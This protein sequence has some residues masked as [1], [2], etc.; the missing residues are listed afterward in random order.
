MGHNSNARR[1]TWINDLNAALP[2][3]R[4]SCHE[5]AVWQLDSELARE[6]RENIW[7][8]SPTR[9]PP[10]VLLPCFLSHDLSVFAFFLHLASVYA[11]DTSQNYIVIILVIIS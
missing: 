8:V 7:N 2:V 5:T 11:T 6:T 1:T 9:Y 10:P 4:W 3:Y